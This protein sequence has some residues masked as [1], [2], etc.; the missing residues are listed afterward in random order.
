MVETLLASGVLCEFEDADLPPPNASINYDNA[1]GP[2]SS[3][4][5]EAQDLL[6]PLVRAVR[7]GNA[8]LVRLLLA[9]GADANVGYHCDSRGLLPLPRRLHGWGDQGAE[10]V[11][12]KVIFSCGRVVQLAME[13]G[14]DEIVRL[15]M[16]SGADACLS[17]PVWDVQ[18]HTCPL[19]PMAAWL[20]VTAGLEALRVSREI[21]IY[22]AIFPTLMPV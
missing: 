16:E 9:R 6:A 14:H 5:L 1:L 21:V 15:L 4:R 13:L 10:A 19:V 22:S 18:G 7:L 3:P 11:P 12:R 17:Q 8:G 2:E 20:E